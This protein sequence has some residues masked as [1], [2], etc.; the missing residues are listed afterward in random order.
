MIL[1][2]VEVVPQSKIVPLLTGTAEPANSLGTKALTIIVP[3]TAGFAVDGTFTL[4]E[5]LVTGTNTVAT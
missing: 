5:F 4:S 3:D 1:F 2:L